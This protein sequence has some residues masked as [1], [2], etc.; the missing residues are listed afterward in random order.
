MKRILRYIALLSAVLLLCCTFAACSNT[1]VV[2]VEG[3]DAPQTSSDDSTWAELTNAEYWS[4]IGESMPEK[5]TLTQGDLVFELE[6]A[7]GHFSL[8]NTSTGKIYHSI[9]QGEVT[10]FDTQKNDRLRSELSI[11]YYN[12]NSE[13]FYMATNPDSMNNET[14]LRILFDGKNT[15]RVYYQLGE[16]VSASLLPEVFEK[17]VYEKDIINATDE[18]GNKLLSSSDARRLDRAYVLFDKST[19]DTSNAKDVEEFNAMVAKYPVLET[20]PLYIVKSSLSANQRVQIPEALQVVGYTIDD[21][22]AAQERLGLSFELELG[23]GFN[24]PVQYTIEDSAIIASVLTDKIEENSSDFKMTALNLLEYFG[25]VDSNG[26]GH[27]LVPDG[28][29]A[30]LQMNNPVSGSYSQAIYGAD[31]VTQADKLNQ[32]NKNALLPVYGQFE[33]DGTALFSIVEGGAAA[34]TIN[35]NTFGTANPVNNIYTQFQLRVMDVTEVESTVAPIFNLYGKHILYE[36]PQ[37]RYT[38]LNG[39]AASYEG[40]A[41]FYREYLEAKGLLKKKADGGEAPL[42][43][44]MAGLF[45]QEATF[46]GVPYTETVQLSTF[47]EIQEVINNLN[48]AGVNNTVLRL[49][50]YGKGGLNNYAYNALRLDGGMGS[51]EELK[52]LAQTVKNKGGQMYMDA[53]FS[54]VYSDGWFDNFSPKEDGARYLTR[55]V[56]LKGEY[57]RIT[58]EYDHTVLSRW[59]ISSA[60]YLKFAKGYLS[61][62]RDQVGSDATDFIGVSYGS[63]GLVLG[64]DNNRKYDLDRAQSVQLIRNTMKTVTEDGVKVVTDGGNMY[65]LSY[66]DAIL[67]VPMYSSNINS[68]VAMVPFYQMVLHGYV[69]YAGTPFNMSVNN[70]EALLK[71]LEYGACLYYSWMTREDSL[72]AGSDLSIKLYSLDY[73]NTYNEAVERYTALKGFYEATATATLDKHEEVQDDVF[74]SVYSDGTTVLVNYNTEAVTVD[75]VALEARD[76]HISLG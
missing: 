50:G 14:Q 64:S 31:Y 2:P 62:L 32:I 45:T 60:S 1:E 9:P 13:E 52:T 19:L 8:T 53:D 72:L 51:I 54:F 40:M 69:D 42:Y 73:K 17:D 44:D 75:G 3:A 23:P 70:D 43:I 36:F 4:G 49:N 63:A 71:A 37:I 58:H 26:S 22:L 67:N 6:L 56:V 11:V 20:T 12:A 38:L 68:E 10:A 16:D 35:A 18:E 28:S 59:F 7:T 47:K 5:W 21:Y 48:A 46:L 66:A 30:L 57:D 65:V 33:D 34:A 76:Y 25:S 15:V 24:I 41:K 29:G 74:R 39:D 61:S 55:S 27:Y